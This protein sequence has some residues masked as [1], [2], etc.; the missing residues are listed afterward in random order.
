MTHTCGVRTDGSIACWGDTMR[1]VEATPPDGEFAS[2]SAGHQ[3]TC[4]VRADGSVACWGNNEYGQ[5]RPP[6]GQFESVSAGR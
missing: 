4:G 6:D 5:A 2:V 1:V 3:H